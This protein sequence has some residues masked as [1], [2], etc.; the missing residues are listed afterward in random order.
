MRTENVRVPKL[1]FENTF[2]ANQTICITAPVGSGKSTLF[3]VVAFCFFGKT[4]RGATAKGL[5]RKGAKD[6]VAEVV[7]SKDG[8]TYQITKTLKTN[9]FRS[10]SEN[11]VIAQ[12]HTQEAIAKIIDCDFETYLQAVHYA[13]L[14]LRFGRLSDSQKMAFLETVFET[15]VFDACLEEAKKQHAA[16]LAQ[17]SE[18]QRQAE[19]CAV[20]LEM[21]AAQQGELQ[22]R[23]NEMLK[24]LS[25]KDKAYLEAQIADLQS[26]IDNDALYRQ[27]AN[28]LQQQRANLESQLARAKGHLELLQS[29]NHDKVLYNRLC[30]LSDKTQSLRDLVAKIEALGKKD[31]CLRCG[32]DFGSTPDPTEN[33]LKQLA[34]AKKYLSY[35]DANFIAQWKDREVEM[36]NISL[37]IDGLV[38]KI[39]GIALEVSSTQKRFAE[40]AKIERFYALKSEVKGIETMELSLA[41]IQKQG[42]SLSSQIAQLVAQ[43]AVFEQKAETDR[44]LLESLAFWVKGFSSK[45]VK[46]LYIQSL[47]TQISELANQVAN[48][49]GLDFRISIDL[50]KKLNPISIEMRQTGLEYIEYPNLSGGQTTLADLVI[51]LTFNALAG[52]SFGYLILDEPLDFLDKAYQTRVAQILQS[53]GKTV[54]V[55]SH[56]DFPADITINLAK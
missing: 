49:L 33:Q 56:R 52:Q 26:D 23:Y 19:L 7:F 9:I 11:K 37:S 5:L 16:I 30:E 6:F 15:G 25:E 3:D 53:L 41:Q 8:H 20:K 10:L 35:F 31:V 46:R 55:I 32:K 4:P 28:T 13:Q 24:S 39:E 48:L 29:L 45:G 47:S 1:A 18:A 40:P 34:T 42:E 44:G 2:A 43:K 22:M 17:I 27:K 14:G 51:F 54:F 12:T 38:A 21:F 36:Q 50:E